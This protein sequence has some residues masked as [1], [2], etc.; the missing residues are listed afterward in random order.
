MS[1]YQL[2]RE[3]NIEKLIETIQSSDNKSIRKR[4]IEIVGNIFESGDYTEE[5]LIIQSNN[6][7]KTLEDE[8]EDAE[9]EG[10]NVI[11]ILL[12]VIVEDDGKIVRAT[13]VDTLDK[14]SQESLERVVERLSG[15]DIQF[16][17]DWAA[18]KTFNK[19]L[20]SE[21]PELRMASAAG[22]GRVG[23]NR[24]IDDLINRLTD[25]DPRVRKRA[26]IACGRV[27]DPSAVEPLES[28]FH[29]EKSMKV[30]RTIPYAL[31]E[32][33]NGGS[34]KVLID[35]S[36]NDSESVRR[37]VANALGEYGSIEAVDTLVKYL[38]DPY[39]PVRRTAIFSMVKIL[40]NANAEQSHKIREKTADELED[41]TSSEV[42]PPLTD[43]LTEA[44]QA[45]QR[46]NSAWLLG[47]I[48]GTQH[49][50][51]VRSAL[52]EALD[53]DDN[54]TAQFAVTSLTKL[55]DPHLESDLLRIIDD[56]E[57]SHDARKKSL[58]ALGKIG[59]ERSKRQIG[60]FVD[61]TDDEDL[62]QQ[63]FQSLSKLGGVGSD[64]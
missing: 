30:K 10:E 14:H 44:S 29:K 37:E 19:Y 62:R 31:G 24:F 55:N 13:A 43:I 16:A 58:F 54:M 18:A 33:G 52:I 5:D 45:P 4:A 64:I 46:R 39:E 28:L 63:A 21:K 9:D 26:V 38:K 47:R 42:I 11:D 32:I 48:V 6:G 50:S 57:K 27:G 3:K 60:E 61:R 23:D 59:G 49:R 35:I 2:E 51:E 56:D 40:S 53:D 25:E 17:A 36:E 15:E 8:L 20:K 22:L 1:L 12:D 41:A 34:M 7:S